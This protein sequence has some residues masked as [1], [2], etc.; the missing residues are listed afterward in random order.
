MAVTESTWRLLEGCRVHPVTATHRPRNC[1]EITTSNSI[2]EKCLTWL[3]VLIWSSVN[4]WRCNRGVSRSLLLSPLSF[5]LFSPAGTCSGQQI[6]GIHR[7][8]FTREVF[9]HCYIE[10]NDDTRP[11]IV[12]GDGVSLTPIWKKILMK[13]WDETR[14]R[15]QFIFEELPEW[16]LANWYRDW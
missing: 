2:R 6:I 12:I 5:S 9:Y 3:L 7:K 14:F 1:H 16:F 13:R 8:H 4:T 15:N 10:N 11:C